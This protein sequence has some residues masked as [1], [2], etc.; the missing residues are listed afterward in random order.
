MN[1]QTVCSPSQGTDHVAQMQQQQRQQQLEQKQ[2]AQ[3]QLHATKPMLATDCSP[4]VAVGRID[5]EKME[6]QLR[7]SLHLHEEEPTILTH[8]PPRLQIRAFTAPEPAHPQLPT[9]KLDVAAVE[10]ALG[11]PPPHRRS[12]EAQQVGLYWKAPPAY[13]LFACV[14]HPHESDTTSRCQLSTHFGV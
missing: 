9:G 14:M 13:P 2:N 8:G 11:S 5:R 6:V 4:P 1:G 7:A 12:L 3:L 10:Q